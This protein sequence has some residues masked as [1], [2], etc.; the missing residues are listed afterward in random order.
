MSSRRCGP[1]DHLP[2]PQAG[3]NRSGPAADAERLARKKTRWYGGTPS[4]VAAQFDFQIPPPTMTDQ[5]R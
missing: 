1:P 2:S 4:H 3:V 5:R